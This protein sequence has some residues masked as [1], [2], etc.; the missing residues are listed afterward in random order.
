MI[1]FSS[2]HSVIVISSSCKSIPVNFFFILHND[3][4][5]IFWCEKHK[6]KINECK[7]KRKPENKKRNHKDENESIENWNINKIDKNK[8]KYIIRHERHIYIDFHL[9]YRYIN[10]QIRIL[11]IQKEKLEIINFETLISIYTYIYCHFRFF[12]LKKK[13]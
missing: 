8:D 9:I 10:I 2:L 7:M 13:L 4:I 5:I 12:F 6:T 11:N 3:F 1:C